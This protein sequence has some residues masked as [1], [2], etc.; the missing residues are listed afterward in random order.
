MYEERTLHYKELLILKTIAETLNQN[1]DMKPMLQSTLE[2][3][4]E[5]TGLKTG[6]IFLADD[7]PIYHHVADHNLPP[8]LARNDKESMRGEV[9]FCLQLYWRDSLN[10]AVNII[11]C[12]RLH[13]S[14]KQSLGDTNNL[15]HHATVPL[16]ICGE[17][18]GLLNVGSPGKEHF[19]DEELALLEGVAYQIGT[20]VERTRLLEQ[21]EKL[22]VDNIARYIVDYYNSTNEVTRHIWAI[23]NLRELLLTVVLNI[24]TYFDWPTV[25]IAVHHGNRLLLRAL[26]DNENARVLNESRLHAEEESTDIIHQ[27]FLERTVC[28]SKDTPFSFA[29]LQPSQHMYSTAIPLQKQEPQLGN[30]PL[31]V[32]LIG[33]ELSTFSGLEIKILTTLADH[34]SLAMERI[35]LYDEWQ[36]LLLSEERNRLALDLHDSVN[37]KL[38]SLSLTAQ[39]IKELLKDENPLVA[40]GISDIQKL[41]QETLS[42]M[43]TLIWQLRPYSA[44]KGMLASLKEYASKLGIHVTLQMKDDVQFTEKVEKTLWRIGQ[45]AINNVS[46]H[47]R[48]NRATIKIQ[49]IEDHIQM[50]IID[51]GCGFVPEQAE[52]KLVTLGIS[53]MNERAAQVNGSLKI[54]STEGKGTIV[55]VTVPRS[56]EN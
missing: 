53:S 5:L 50:S 25:A 26:Y 2:K 9:C 46:K 22:A 17:R 33:R 48:T 10:Q 30:E 41:S 1:H 7:E 55:A 18:F 38:F 34:I 43:R 6:W 54:N 52:T 27:A 4:L 32:L 14:V 47:A 31:G 23:N 21:K 56:R 37:Q 40:D 8:A 36:D 51:Y 11:E 3:L 44:E 15:T 42:E 20:A 49:S 13:D 28:Q 16:T 35:R 29:A 19:S 45:E 39:G 24:G 12:E